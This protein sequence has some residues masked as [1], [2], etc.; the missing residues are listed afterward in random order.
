V[1]NQNE[2][3][4]REAADRIEMKVLFSVA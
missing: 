4:P 2:K 1:I 3:K